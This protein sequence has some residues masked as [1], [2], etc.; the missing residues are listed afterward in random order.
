VTVKLL[1]VEAFDG[2]NNADRDSIFCDSAISAFSADGSIPEDGM[3]V[4]L[5]ECS[6]SMNIAR[7]I[8]LSEVADLAPLLEVQREL[9]LRK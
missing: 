7:Q 6:K 1:E 4:V 5:D 9:G 3:R 2:F 8:P